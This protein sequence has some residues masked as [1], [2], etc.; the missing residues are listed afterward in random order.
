MGDIVGYDEYERE[1]RE[2]AL[3]E[4]RWLAH[5]MLTQAIQDCGCQMDG[6]VNV[7]MPDY[8]SVDK[9]WYTFQFSVHALDWQ[10]PASRTFTYIGCY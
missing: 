3:P 1:F 6:M 9:C 8:I 7:S 4:Y 2:T 5:S 10:N